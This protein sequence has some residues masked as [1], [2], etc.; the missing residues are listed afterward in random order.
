MRFDKLTTRFQQALADA[1][2]AGGIA[3]VEFFSKTNKIGEATNGA[4]YFMVL[5]NVAAGDYTFVALATDA[6][7]NMAASAPVSITVLERAPLTVVSAMHFNPQTGLFEET[8]RVSNPTYSTFDVVRLYVSGL[9]NGATVYNPSGTNGGLQYVQSFGPVAPGSYVDFLIEYYVPSRVL[10]YPTL[11][12]Q[13]V[14][15]SSR[16]NAVGIRQH[17]DRGVLLP[18][19]TFLIEFSSVSNRL[20]NVQYSSDLQNWQ[21]AFPA[22]TGNGT[23]IQWIDNGQPKTASSPATQPVRFYRLLLMP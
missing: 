23:H 21:T 8:V 6:C 14:T 9:T 10:P 16:G 22:I 18:E 15:P 12:P 7:G 19:K 2:D 20:Y 1:Q 5:T 4:P 3:R 11:I 17:I 13:L